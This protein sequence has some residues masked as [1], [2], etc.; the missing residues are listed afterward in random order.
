MVQYLLSEHSWWL[1]KTTTNNKTWLWLYSQLRFI[2]VKKHKGQSGKKGAWGEVQGKQAWAFNRPLPVNSHSICV[3]S[4]TVSCDGISKRCQPGSSL[5]TQG[6]AFLE[7]IGHEGPLYLA[8]S[9]VSDFWKESRCSAQTV[10]FIQFRNRDE[11]SLSVNGGNPLK[12]QLSKR[13]PRAN[14]VK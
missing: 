5:E 8:R 12:I 7:G 11:H 2:T 3:N 4:P 10:L 9:P 14:F 1:Y 13:E 6:P